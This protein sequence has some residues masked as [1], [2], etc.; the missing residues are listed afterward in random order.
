MISAFELA[1]FN[2]DILKAFKSGTIMDHRQVLFDF[3]NANSNHIH[4]LIE[5][6]AEGIESGCCSGNKL[7]IRLVY[8]MMFCAFEIRNDMM[9]SVSLYQQL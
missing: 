8:A 3:L 4:Q 7:R 9:L 2:K 5:E 6:E 1:L